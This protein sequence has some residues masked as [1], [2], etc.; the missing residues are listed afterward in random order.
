MIVGFVEVISVLPGTV[1]EVKGVGISDGAITILG[2]S[3]SGS[4]INTRF[5]E[6]DATLFAVEGGSGSIHDLSIIHD[7]EDAAGRSAR[8]FKIQGSGKCKLSNLNISMNSAHSKGNYLLNSLVSLDGGELKMQDVKWDRIFSDTCLISLSQ[9]AATLFLLNN[10][11]F[12]DIIRVSDGCSLVST[13]SN[14]PDLTIKACTIVRCGS[15]ESEKGGALDLKVDASGCLKVE[16]GEIRNCFASTVTGRG[17]GMFLTVTDESAEYSITTLFTDNEARWGSDIFVDSV[18]LECTATGRKISSVTE[19][20]ATI[21]TIRGFDG[22][23]ERVRIPL[24]VYLIPSPDELVVSDKDSFD[25]LHCG[26]VEFPCLTLKHTLERQE[27]ERKVCVNGIISMTDEIELEAS[28]YAIRGQAEGSGWTVGEDANGLELLLVKI[29]AD[30]LLSQLLFALPSEMQQ[31]NTLISVQSAAKLTMEECSASMKNTGTELSFAFME[32]ISGTVNITQFSANSISLAG[33]PLISLGGASTFGIIDRLEMDEVSSTANCELINIRNGASMS[34]SNSKITGKKVVQRNLLLSLRFLSTI[35][36]KSVS[37]MNCSIIGFSSFEKNGGAIECVLGSECSF[38]VVGGLME[39]GGCISGNGGGLCIEM[40]EGSRFSIGNVSNAEIKNEEDSERDGNGATELKNCTS[41]RGEEGNGGC[42]GGLCLLL[43]GSASDFILKEVIFEECNADVGKSMFVSSED[44]S[45]V[46]NRNKLG[47]NFNLTDLTQMCGCEGGRIKENNAIPLVLY[48]WTNMS[49]E[50]HAG[51]SKSGDAAVCGFEEYPCTTIEKALKR[52]GKSDE[53]TVIVRGCAEMRSEVALNGTS[54]V[55]SGN[56][57][58][59]SI[60]FASN[61]KGLERKIVWCNGNLNIEKIEMQV[62]LSFDSNADVLFYSDAADGNVKIKECC[63]EVMSSE[64]GYLGFS[65]ISAPKGNVFVNSTN[66]SNLRSQREL[67]AITINS[68]LDLWNTAVRDLELKGKSAIVVEC[69]NQ[70]GMMEENGD[71][72]WNVVIVGCSLEN[73]DQN[74]SQHPSLIEWP[75]SAGVKMKVEN[76]TM[77]GC[78]SDASSK[79]GGVM[80]SLSDGGWMEWVNSFVLSC[81]CSLAGRGGGMYLKSSCECEMKLPFVLCGVTFLGNK[82][83]RGRDVYVQCQNIENQ[84][85]EEQFVLDFRLPFVKELAMWGCPEGGFASEED[86][87]LMVIV[88]RSETIFVSGT[89]MNSTST[90]QC[91]EI[92][93]P[94]TSLDIGARHV[95]GSQYSQILVEKS[96]TLE[97]ELLLKSVSVRS[98]SSEMSASV[99][100]EGVVMGNAKSVISVKESA[101][102]ERILFEFC[103]RIESEHK[104]LIEAEDCRF[105]LYAVGFRSKESEEHTGKA[106]VPFCLLEVK[107][108]IVMFDSCTVSEL[109]FRNCL[110]RFV[111]ANEIKI[112]ELNASMVNAWKSLIEC[113]ACRSV[114]ISKQD[115]DEV[116]TEQGSLLELEDCESGVVNVSLVNIKNITSQAER[117]SCICFKSCLSMI[118]LSYCSFG[119]CKSDLQKGR[120]VSLD[121]CND[122]CISSCTFD[123]GSDTEEER[124]ESGNELCKWN[125]SLLDARSSNIVMKDTT[126]TCSSAG[127]LSISG[128]NM[129]IEKG[130]FKE[131]SPLIANY[132]SARRNIMC[133]DSGTLNI[134]SLKGG[135]GL[136]DNTSLWILNEGCELRGMEAERPSEL[137]IP[138]LESVEAEEVEGETVLI[139]KGQ[140]LLPCDLSFWISL[141]KTGSDFSEDYSFVDEGYKSENEV[142]GRVPSLRVLNAGSETEVSVGI[143]FG[144]SKC[145]TESFILKNRSESQTSG[146]ERIAE[147]GKE[148]KSSWAL[149]VII[150]AIVLLIVLIASIVLAVRWR[151]AK[152]EAEDLREIVNDNIR[153]DPKAFEMVT[154]EMS[155]EEQWR[156]AEREAEKKDEERMK[157]RVYAKSLQH[158]E[159]S[160]HLLAESGSTEYILGKDSDKIPEWALEKVEEEDDISRKRSPSPST[161]STSSTDTSDTESTFVR[162]EDLCPTTSSMSNLVD[163]MACSSPHEKLIVDLRDSLFMLLHGRNKTKEMAI[164]TLQERE[165]SAAQILFWV[166]NLALHS[167]DEMENKLQSLANLSPHIV[168]F[169][170]HMVICIV[171]HSDLLSDDSSDSSSISSSTV[172][173]SA[174]DDD[175]NDDSLPSSAFEDEDSFKKECLRWKAPELL[176]NK[177]MKATK[178]SVVFSIGMMLWECLTLHIPFGE[179]EAVIAGDKIAKGEALSMCGNAASSFSLVVSECLSFQPSNRPSLVSILREFFQKFP[180]SAKLPTMTDAL[181]TNQQSAISR[182]SCCSY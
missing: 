170:E 144:S 66:I 3:S 160:E 24:C 109:S 52:L 43:A 108:G 128:G 31:H 167:F 134:Q 59:A 139:F 99:I 143:Y 94:C 171:M 22:G 60:A 84:V 165:V 142:H 68:Q 124:N 157:K 161:S 8:L 182:N 147:R 120:I 95:I 173:T 19:S 180:E 18:N 106:D 79:G 72:E 1:V 117:E 151:K 150:M 53:K 27:G 74:G 71:D 48:F 121:Q 87:L 153:K 114:T 33:F 38:E 39:N 69:A 164:G 2:S 97:N 67:I 105:R 155:P 119:G 10:C 63:F 17:G 76:S 113:T 178:K 75:G 166:A 177:N 51:G 82:A 28:K 132:P 112:T 122:V 61:L 138:M 102:F 56:D 162:R 50:A 7:T 11:T 16:D 115:V 57:E 15:A 133:S 145:S 35:G 172:V 77:E 64:G 126:I 80:F 156:R 146:D 123:G 130:E 179:Y 116:N 101:T 46:I 44:L 12:I 168:L 86:L 93:S 88:Y 110:F 100:V 58:V 55:I 174:S 14:L 135:D 37:L 23:D 41:I 175:D 137:F 70:K 30:T 65:L 54:T 45:P 96:T 90:K 125:G 4:F 107:G 47:F 49:K 98:F 42:G 20:N 85:G 103:E 149:I 159:S 6:G 40:K 127:A 152:N 89:A 29:K 131:N 25:H 158:S 111:E 92:T 163:A 13:N 62:P 181:F 104:S 154:M 34:V 26:F 83:F 148:G 118:E 78:G 36:G 21:N 73:I 136:K 91:G 129:R 5:K 9:S 169:S 141:K 32:V 176:I 81:F 140:L